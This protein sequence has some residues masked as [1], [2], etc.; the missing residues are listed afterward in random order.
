MSKSDALLSLTEFR[1]IQ[2]MVRIMRIYMLYRA[3]VVAAP[4]SW[5]TLPDNVRDSGSYSNF[6][7]ELKTHYFNIAFYNHIIC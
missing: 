1:H 6:L 5:N 4:S 3:F 2:C 7:S